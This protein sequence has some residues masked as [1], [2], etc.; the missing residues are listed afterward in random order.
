MTEY[1]IV[2][3]SC[4]FEWGTFWSAFGAIFTAIASVAI[5]LGMRQLQFDAWLK[6]Q[7]LITKDDFIKLRTKIFARLENPDLP[8]TDTE[9]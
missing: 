4:A 6:A 9:K 7:E 1:N 3:A 5:V 8:W 2:L